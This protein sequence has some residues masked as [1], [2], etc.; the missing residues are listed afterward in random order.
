[1]ATLTSEGY[2]CRSTTSAARARSFLDSTAYDLLLFGLSQPDIAD[3]DR[4]RNLQSDY[5]D[6]GVVIVSAINSLKFARQIA[7]LNFYGHILKPVIRRQAIIAVAYALQRRHLEQ[8]VTSHRE[9][10]TQLKADH[11]EM[12]T[13][14]Q[15]LDNALNV[16]L[17]KRDQDKLDMGDQVLNNI[18]KVIMPNLERLQKFRL[19]PRHQRMLG[20]IQV[21][22]EEIASPFV[23]TLSSAF[24]ALTP[25][26]IQVADL[27]KQGKSTKEIA[28]I[29]NLS[30]NTI[31]THR[32]HIR[33]KLGLKNKKTHLNTFLNTL[34]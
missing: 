34:Q 11:Q 21:N 16:L 3:L 10:V 27:I 17:K 24:H 20:L 18:R 32:Y 1:M 15:A 9:M 26:E 22:L 2:L 12:E 28:A 14:Y 30:T 8:A 7:A 33:T 19:S 13:G 31:M 5:P 29:M 25:N 6:M 23:K 4:C